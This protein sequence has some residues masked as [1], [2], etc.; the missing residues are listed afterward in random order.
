MNVAGTGM[1]VVVATRVVDFRK[2]HDGP[3]AER[4]AGLGGPLVTE[5][6]HQRRGARGA[7]DDAGAHTHAGGAP[8]P[9]RIE[10]VL[11]RRRG[12]AER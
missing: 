3:A 1:R 8:A 2:G 5:R 6:E 9:V 4:S 12:T 10:V 11:K 7:G